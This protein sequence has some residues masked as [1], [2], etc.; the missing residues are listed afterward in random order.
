M[1]S[2]CPSCGAKNRVPVAAK[3][4]PRCAS[5]RAELPWVVEADDT[6][7][8]AAVATNLLTLVDLWAPWCRPC[9]LV[10]P[11]L[12][13]LATDYAGRLKVVKVNVDVNRSTS[14]RFDA[15]S[16]PLLVF[17]RDGRTVE[18]VLG[19]Q[20][21]RVLRAKVEHHLSTAAGR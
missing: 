13:K 4:R 5:C 14:A 17:L 6:G 9:Q 3:G 8:A 18:T 16:I 7:F 11:V 2:R 20:P 1:I 12:E 19:A 15:S 21:D 10:A